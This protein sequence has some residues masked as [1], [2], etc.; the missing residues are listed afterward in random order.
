[1]IFVCKSIFMSNIIQ[2]CLFYVMLCCWAVKINAWCAHVNFNHVTG[3]GNTEV[4][5]NCQ[6]LQTVEVY[7]IS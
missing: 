6:L 4:E 1:M 3:K 7:V 2:M 5:I